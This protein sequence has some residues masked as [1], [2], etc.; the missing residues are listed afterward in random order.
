MILMKQAES[1]FVVKLYYTFQG[2][3]NLYLVIEYLNGGDCAA[4]IKVV[5]SLPEEWAK[6]YVAEAVLGPEY[7]HARGVIHR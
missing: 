7:P 6:A 4:L 2:K 1:P 3:D 5:G